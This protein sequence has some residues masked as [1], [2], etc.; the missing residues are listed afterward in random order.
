M[1]DGAG[2]GGQ[3]VLD[4]L[5]LNGLPD[6]S[7]SNT[8]CAFFWIYNR[9]A[10]IAREIDDKSIVDGG[11]T[12][13]AMPPTANSKLQMILAR[14]LQG[15]NNILRVFYESH[16]SSIPLGIG[17]PP[18]YR[19]VVVHPNFGVRVRLRSC[20]NVSLEGLLQDVYVRH[21]GKRG[22]RGTDSL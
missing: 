21:S 9:V 15:E 12:G 14:I 2:Y 4:G 5:K 19:R 18:S 1:I 16:D 22:N 17:C 3:L 8:H 10:E 11:S 13:G 20:D 6:G 7:S